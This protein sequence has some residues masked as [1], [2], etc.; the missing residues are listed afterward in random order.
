M[1]TKKEFQRK[2]D[3]I[4]EEISALERQQDLLVKN[5]EG[6]NLDMVRCEFI[7]REVVY[8][9]FW[10]TIYYSHF[11]G[12]ASGSVNHLSEGAIEITTENFNILKSLIKEYKS[13]PKPTL[14]SSVK[15]DIEALEEKA[16]WAI[17]EVGPECIHYGGGILKHF[18][19]EDEDTLEWCYSGRQDQGE[20]R[21][22][23]SITI[24]KSTKKQIDS[25]VWID[26]TE[27][28]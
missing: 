26:E 17:E 25:I 3:E 22:G 15:E 12:H 18:E 10:D 28:D 21:D 6:H 23:S 14:G 13:L 19:I 27:T 20:L 9:A 16:S 2:Y 7:D 5:A 11:D 4:K 1:N 8:G 24:K